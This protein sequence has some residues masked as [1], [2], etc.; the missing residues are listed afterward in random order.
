MG[1]KEARE[2][3]YCKVGGGGGSLDPEE[4]GGE[5]DASAVEGTRHNGPGPAR[6]PLTSS[7][8][9]GS[10]PRGVRRGQVVE[11]QGREKRKTF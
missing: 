9:P 8:R 11:P 1:E 2:R 3:P 4:D 7:V 5:I 6:K 10:R